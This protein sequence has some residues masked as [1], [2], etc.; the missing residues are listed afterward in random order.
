[1]PDVEPAR[2]RVRRAVQVLLLLFL[3]TSRARSSLW[4]RILPR[5]RWG[6]EQRTQFSRL[7]GGEAVRAGEGRDRWNAGD[8][9]VCRRR[10][11]ADSRFGE[12]VWHCNP[13]NYHVQTVPRSRILPCWSSS[14]GAPTIQDTVD[15]PEHSRDYK[16]NAQEQ[17]PVNVRL[18]SRG[19]RLLNADRLVDR[20]PLETAHRR[21][22]GLVGRPR[23]FSRGVLLWRSATRD[24]TWLV[25]WCVCCHALVHTARQRVL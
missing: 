5:W 24:D 19:Q 13:P 23:Q 11:M 16:R 17:R 10:G 3:P 4:R 8:A 12:R 6:D 22:A 2:R 14:I 1:M 7:H 25:N 9:G 20:L 21:T 15:Q 18:S